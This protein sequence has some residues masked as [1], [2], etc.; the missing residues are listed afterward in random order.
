MP[1]NDD[2]PPGT[3]WDVEQVLTGLR[4]ARHQWRSAHWRNAEIGAAGFPSRRTLEEVMMILCGV[5]FPLRLGPSYVR[6]SNEDAFVA[7]TLENGLGHLYGQLRRELTYSSID[8]DGDRIDEEARRIISHF[9]SALPEIRVLLDKDVEAAFAGD[10]AAASVDEVLLCYPCLLAII[11]YRLANRLHGLGAPLVARIIT[12]IAHSRT[13]IDIHPG[14]QIGERFFID[15]GTGVVIGETAVIGHRVRLYQA[16]TLGA[17]TLPSDH[18][19]DLRHNLARHPIIEDDVVIYPG[20]TLLGRITVGRGSVI[21]G[22]VWL[23]ESIPPGSYVDQ[24]EL[25]FKDHRPA[26]LFAAKETAR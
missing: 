7:E 26:A 17:L 20:A 1:T 22:N 13:G 8:G 25:R 23:I 10:P 2:L 4:A 24:G 15:H 21:G 3:L 16:V 5:L 6:K 14:A 18:P 9:A 12:E 11:H 19:G